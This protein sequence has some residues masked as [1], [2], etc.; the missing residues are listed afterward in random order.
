MKGYLDITLNG[1]MDQ[2]SEESKYKNFNESTEDFGESTEDMSISDAMDLWLEE[3]DFEEGAGLFAGSKFNKAIQNALSATY[4]LCRYSYGVEKDG[5]IYNVDR[6]EYPR[7][8]HY[9][10][11]QDFQ[12]LKGGLSFDYCRFLHP[13]LVS[14][15]YDVELFF[16]ELEGTNVNHAFPMIKVPYGDSFKYLYCEAA[17]KYICGCYITT[18]LDDMISAIVSVLREFTIITK[19]T[20]VLIRKYKPVKNDD[21]SYAELL[22]ELRKNEIYDKWVLKPRANTGSSSAKASKFNP[23]LLTRINP[24]ISRIS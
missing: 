5:H 23:G 15:G 12:R 24:E 1:L 8:Y 10:S 18:N 7:W 17:L 6:S 9:L 3:S 20:N 13:Y 14:K 2:L 11:R 16:I 4:A 19:P 21:L 22:K